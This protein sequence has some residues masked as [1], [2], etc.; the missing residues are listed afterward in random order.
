[1]ATLI[2]CY[3]GQAWAAKVVLA[4]LPCYLQC[5]WIRFSELNQT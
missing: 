2:G 3:V 4:Q 1:M 5:D